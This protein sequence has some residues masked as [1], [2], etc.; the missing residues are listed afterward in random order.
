MKEI[1]SWTRSLHNT[2]ENNYSGNHVLSFDDTTTPHW[3]VPFGRTRRGSSVKAAV[4]LYLAHFVHMQHPKYASYSSCSYR[5]LLRGRGACVRQ[6]NVRDPR[7][8]LRVRSTEVW[9]RVCL[10]RHLLVQPN[11]PAPVTR[12]LRPFRTD[13][14][15]ALSRVWRREKT[16]KIITRS[17]QAI[18]HTQYIKFGDCVVA[19]TIEE[20]R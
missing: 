5:R 11:T 2:L 19:V 1:P 17:K 10:E 20:N 8:T 16:I 13:S 3:A 18:N 6:T 14:L 7:K 15:I 12:Y 4:P 9:Q